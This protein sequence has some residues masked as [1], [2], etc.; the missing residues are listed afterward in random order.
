MSDFKELVK[1][2]E[3][4]RSYVRD[5][6]IYGFKTREDFTDKSARTYDNERRRIE[7]WFS[8]YVRQ[9]Y[10]TGHKKSVF[11]TLDSNRIASNPLYHAFCLTPRLCGESWLPMSGKVW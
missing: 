3:K 2:F 1:R 7:S 4:I 5:F 6:Y 9:E 8:G 10:H 11:I